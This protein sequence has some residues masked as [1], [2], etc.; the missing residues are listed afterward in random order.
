MGSNLNLIELIFHFSGIASVM[1]TIIGIHFK[2]NSKL[3]YTLFLSSVIN[4]VNMQSN[5]QNSGAIVNLI[6]VVRNYIAIKFPNKSKIKDILFFIFLFLY[7]YISFRYG[8]LYWY[9][10]AIGGVAGLIALFKLTKT[11]TRYALLFATF[12]WLIY[13][14]LSGNI[15]GILNEIIIILSFVSSFILN[16][17]S[18]ED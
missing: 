7:V 17:G 18:Y 12:N 6:S 2:S 14:F 3:K 8:D 13:A 11:K 4:A 5:L 9:L 10:P 16:K 1:I 15:Y